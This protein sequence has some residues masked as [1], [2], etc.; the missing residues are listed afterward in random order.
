MTSRPNGLPSSGWAWVYAITCVATGKQYVGITGFSV[1]RRW[2]RHCNRAGWDKPR[3]GNCPALHAAIRKYGEDAFTCEPIFAGFDWQATLDAEIALIRVLRTKAPHGYNVTDGGE[4]Q[5]GREVSDAERKRLGDISRGKKKSPETLA[6]LSASLKGRTLSPQHV[7]TLRDRRMTEAQRA[8]MS[9]ARKGRPFPSKPGDWTGK[10]H[11]EAT[12]QKMSAWQVG[13]ILAAATKEKIRQAMAGRKATAAAIEANR[14]GQKG[15]VH[16]D[17]TKE[18]MRRKTP[19]HPVRCV[20][21]GES[22][23][24]M[25]NAALLI[26][27]PKTSIRRHLLGSSP[28]VRGFVFERIP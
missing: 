1:R 26:G 2:R 24:S 13:K 15:R 23:P 7:Q 12:K 8:A 27:L 9:L 6:R 4:G 19:C 20:T 11:T 16:S 18:K 22:Y 21:T 28:A 10:K 25:K 3:N 5:R 14:K 17:Q